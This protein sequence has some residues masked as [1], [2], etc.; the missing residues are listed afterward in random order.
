MEWTADEQYFV[1]AT[2]QNTLELFTPE[3]PSSN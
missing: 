1:R 3:E 2:F